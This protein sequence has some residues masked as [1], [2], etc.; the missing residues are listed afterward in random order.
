M[1]FY[2][3]G[4]WP[5]RR[6]KGLE[7]FWDWSWGRSLMLVRE[8]LCARWLCS[9]TLSHGESW[10]V[11]KTFLIKQPLM[12][13]LQD[14]FFC[15][16]QSWGAALL[17]VVFYLELP[18]RSSYYHGLPACRWEGVQGCWGSANRMTISP[19]PWKLNMLILMLALSITWVAVIL[20]NACI[21]NTRFSAGDKNK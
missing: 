20:L 13:L 9:L 19:F 16:R 6:L 7:F 10:S 21:Q 12:L 15:Y 5:P 1:Y 18:G 2:L 8:E 11:C 3:H 17:T 4:S 14:P